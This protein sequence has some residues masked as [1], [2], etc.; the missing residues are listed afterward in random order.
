MQRIREW[1]IG[2]ERSVA[3]IVLQRRDMFR[4]MAPEDNLVAISC[5]GDGKSGAVEPAPITV[6]A[7]L[8]AFIRH[9]DVVQH[10]RQPAAADS[11]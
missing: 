1:N 7:A 10:L 8:S 4:V 6:I 5:G 11:S 2:K 9:P 3:A